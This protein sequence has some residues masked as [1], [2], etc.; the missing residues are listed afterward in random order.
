MISGIGM[1]NYSKKRSRH[2]VRKTFFTFLALLVVV[3]LGLPLFKQMPAVS[4]DVVYAATQT[5]VKHPIN[6]PSYGQAAVGT[7]E[8]GLIETHGKQTAVPTAS[9]VKI[10]VALAVLRQ[11]PLT[12][13]Q[14]KSPVITIT[15]DDVKSY[16]DFVAKDGSVVP[17]N[18][19]EQLSEYQMLQALLLPSANNIAFSLTNW[20]FGSQQDYLSYAN[21]MVAQM[22]LSQTHIADASGFSPK[23]V[24]SARDMYILA[25]YALKDRV[26]SEIV[27]QKAVPFPVAGVIRNTNFLLGRD[28][29]IGIKTGNTDEAGG[30]Y[31]FASKQNIG[32]T[33][34][35]LVGS[36]M[37]APNLLVAMNDSLKIIES[38]K[39]QFN[40]QTV[41]KKGQT[42]AVYKTD[43]GE[44]VNAVA[45][46]DA[47]V[48][49]RD[50]QAPKADVDVGSISPYK[51]VGTKVGVVSYVGQYD[52][53][54][55]NTDVVLDSPLNKPS[56]FWSITHPSS[57]LL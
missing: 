56:Y 39:K 12:P 14:T 49:T 2:G 30:C 48:L 44:S 8:S 36:I 32:G 6:W 29:I 53:K 46:S 10:V 26:I 1:R 9:T 50:N 54:K 17:V 43:W 45:N 18:E 40:V 51:S 22:G 4:P 42:I 41:I 34:I 28:G 52:G 47:A 38:A 3:Y 37:A 5:A 15:A 27:S 35:T 31:V 16:N 55:N 20:A 57:Y 19:G 21:N 23:T 7:L 25:Q 13:D 24:S 33:P 11:K